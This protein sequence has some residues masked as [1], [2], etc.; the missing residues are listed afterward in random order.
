MFSTSA[1]FGD[2]IFLRWRLTFS[3]RISMNFSPGRLGVLGLTEKSALRQ[4]HELAN[5]GKYGGLS[6]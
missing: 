2:G 5:C 6:N 3:R 4:L 1:H